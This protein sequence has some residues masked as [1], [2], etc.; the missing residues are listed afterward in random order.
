MGDDRCKQII[1]TFYVKLYRR[2][3]KY[4]VW[5][6]TAVYVGGSGKASLIR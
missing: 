5:E 1:K 6:D 2:G 3:I 4:M